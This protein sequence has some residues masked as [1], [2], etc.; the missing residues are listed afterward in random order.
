MEPVQVLFQ[1]EE[2]GYAPIIIQSTSDVKMSEVIDKFKNKASDKNF[3]DYE[4]YFNDKIIIQDLKL[5]HFQLGEKSSNNPLIIIISVRKRS[6]ITKCPNCLANT[7][8]LKI[9]NFGLNFSGC[10]YNHKSTKT[11][12]QYENSQKINYSEIKCDKCSKSLK[13][14]KEMF[15][16]LTCSNQIQLSYYFCDECNA[17][18]REKHLEFSKVKHDIIKYED[19]NY[20]CLD[21]CEYSFYCLNCEC[22]LCEICEKTHNKKHNIIKYDSITPKIKSIKR[23]LEKIKLKI[24][25]SKSH[26]EQIL[27]MIEDASQTLDNYYIICMDIV[28]KCE[29]YNTKLKNYHVISNLNSLEKSN[30]VVLNNLNELLKGD[31]SKKDYL[32]KC[33][34]LFDIF[35]KERGNLTGNNGKDNNNNN[36]QKIEVRTQNDRNYINRNFKEESKNGKSYK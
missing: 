15:K 36:S 19:K 30:Q 3:K 33:D 23:E 34:I 14:V 27:R 16:C 26:I 5:S 22:D 18:F 35:Y 20:Y 8:F 2:R 25:E 17:K 12:S 28:G 1:F 13:E 10:P 29:L 24:D 6:F 21:G 4:F 11:F 31:N 9:E 7:C 32:S